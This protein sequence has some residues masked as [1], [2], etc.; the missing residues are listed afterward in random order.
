[1]RKQPYFGAL[2]AS[3]NSLDSLINDN[4]RLFDAFGSRHVMASAHMYKKND[5]DFLFIVDLEKAAKLKFIQEY[6][7]NLS[8]QGF[9]VTKRRYEGQ[10]ITE[11]YDKASRQTLYITFIE[12]L[13][14]CSYTNSLLEASIDQKDDPRI[15]RDTRFVE[16]SKAISGN[17]LFNVYMQYAYLDEYMRCYMSE[18]NEYVTSLSKSLGF[19]G[20]SFSLGEDGK[21][22]LDGYTNIHDSIS[23]Y[24]RAMLTSGKGK[25]TAQ[26]VIPQRT[27]FYMSLTVD[28]F[29]TF[30]D[31]FE[32]SMKDNL[33][34]YQE[35]RGN[36]DRIEKF[37][38]ISLRNNFVKWIG[39]EVA[40]VQTQPKG[41][42]KDN[43]F[44]VIVKTK[45]VDEARENMDFITKQIRKKT[46]VKFKGVDYKGYTINFMSVKGFFKLIF[47]KF[48]QKLDKPYFTVI[49][50]YVVFSNHPQTIKNIIND[51][52][53]KKTLDQSEQFNNFFG[54]FSSS[55]NVFIYI[56]TPVL[57]NNL[58]GFVSGATWADMQKNKNY[59]VCF[60][61]MGLQ[62]AEDN[63][64]FATKLIT[65]FHDPEEVT[66]NDL[67]A[68]IDSTHVSIQPADSTTQ[69]EEEEPD[70]IILDDLDV[71]RYTE[72]YPDGSKKVEAVIKD[73][74]RNGAYREYYTN[75]EVKI[76]GHYQDD[77]KNGT[78]KYYDES[79]KLTEK[80]KFDNG[81][82]VTD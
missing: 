81:Q 59:I 19:T 55:S 43:E 39:Q 8:S 48:F 68:S 77:L 63:S 26:E 80:K 74:L 49:D 6:L 56:Q 2:T 12:N 72:S 52:V 54:E 27:A 21:M 5:Y 17:G 44:A 34:E 65:T 67:I 53:D 36:V 20:A 38:K 46:P 76:K 30:Y 82:E 24:L 61:Q 23:P 25:L 70:E 13:L 33:K 14:V 62:L 32:K 3:A 50:D 16:V 45:D 75:G 57:H 37:L 15:G 78:W 73:G 35:Y 40:F 66:D 29:P 11:L 51:Y 79:G 7:T 41:L 4:S 31:S 64:L 10:Q 28:D 71:K 1:M 22:V 58:K 60:P 9:R 18:A 69:I 42:G 47:G